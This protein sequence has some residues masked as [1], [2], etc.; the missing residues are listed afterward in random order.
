AYPA[1]CVNE[2]QVCIKLFNSQADARQ[3]HHAGLRQLFMNALPEQ[4]RHTQSKLPDID[5]LCLQYASLG[6]CNSLKQDI[7]IACI[8]KLFM[9]QPIHSTADFNTILQQGRGRLF[10]TAS[11][12]CKLLA[13]ILDEYQPL[14]K[15]LNKPPL[16]WLDSL[17]DIQQ[18]LQA[19]LPT[20]FL[21][22]T[23]REW[24]EHYPRYLKAIHK[25]L[26]K[27]NDNP[28]RERSLR[29][30]VSAL[31]HAW[32][33]RQEQLTKQHLQSAKLEHYRWLLEEYRVSLFAQELKTIVPVSAKRLKE[34]WNSIDDA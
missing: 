11:E 17:N 21:L 29:L 10:E 28:A 8:E 2:K 30:E 18:Q 33:Q 24:L 4:I 16:H 12:L 20:G 31:H 14:R 15:L 26:E 22:T 34:Y 19:L 5:K 23:P 6:A 3:H 9:Q 1:L 13:R 27:I 25:R 7:I 32:Q